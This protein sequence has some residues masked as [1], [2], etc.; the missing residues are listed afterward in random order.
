[1]GKE[2][3]SKI[4]N[5]VEVKRNYEKYLTNKRIALVGPGYHTKNTKQCKLIESY[6]I[7]VRINDG[8]SLAE[9]YFNDIGKRTDIL[10]CTLNNFYFVNSN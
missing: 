8:I 9:K 4:F 10:Y 2:I 3:K 5:N 6:D 1:M 7:V